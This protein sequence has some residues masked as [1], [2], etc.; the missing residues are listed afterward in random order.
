MFFHSFILFFHPILHFYNF[1]HQF[2]PGRGTLIDDI[3][4]TG[5][6][7]SGFIESV[8]LHFVEISPYLR[9]EQW[10]KLRCRELRGGEK[11]GE[12]EILDLNSDEG[13]DYFSSKHRHRF[14]TENGNE[15]RRGWKVVGD[16]PSMTEEEKKQEERTSVYTRIES[17]ISEEYGVK[18]TWYHSGDRLPNGPSLIVAHEFLDALPIHRFRFSRVEGWKEVLIDHWRAEEEV[19]HE[20]DPGI[21]FRYVMS[22]HPTPASRVCEP[23][24]PEHRDSREVF[25]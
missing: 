9:K 6:Q 7:F 4:R 5:K 20:K 18:V 19:M 21:A 15:E 8:S 11:E 17:G 2:G 24:L 1:L 12:A 3:L 16:T 13:E 10:K 22:P 25:L 23:F 14:K